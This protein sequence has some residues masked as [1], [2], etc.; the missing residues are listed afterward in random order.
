MV[1]EEQGLDQIF[2]AVVRSLDAAPAVVKP[3]NDDV[4]TS[5]RRRRRNRRQAG[6]A[7]SPAIAA[8]RAPYVQRRIGVF[9]VL[10]DEGAELIE[11]NAETIL[12]EIGM[13]FRD[14]PEVLQIL[15][16]AGA[17]V[18]GERVRFERGMCRKIIQASAPKSFT[19]HARNPANTVRIGAENTVFGPTFGAPFVHDLDNGRRYATLEDQRNFVKL[20]YLSPGL[21]HS[22]GILSEPVDLPVNKRHF[23]IVYSHIRYSDK[24]FF[25]SMLGTERA[26]DSVTMAKLVFGDEFVENNTV[27]YS[28][29]N[30]NAPLVLDATM[31]GSLKTYARHNQAVAISPFILSGAMSPCT[32]AGTLSQ[33]FAEVLGGLSLVQLVRPGAPCL[34]GTF[35]SAISMQSGAPTFGTPEGSKIIFGAAKL[36]RRLGVPYH[37]MGALNASKLP[38]AQAGYEGALTMQSALL[39]GANYII[40]AAGWLESGLTMGYEKFVIDADRCAAMEVFARGIELD[41]NQQA[42]DAV[43]EVGP[44]GHY[45]GCEHTQQNFR[46]A[47]YRSAVADY[48]S[49]EQWSSEGGL[50]QAQKANRIWKQMLDDYQAPDIDSAV[51][52]ALLEF[53]TRRKASMPDTNA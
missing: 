9:D 46:S 32:V 35:A 40:H 8:P 19:Q 17:D 41:E 1:I 49:F 39:A 26:Q 13:E 29:S 21:H 23:D 43:R 36:A 25:G 2:D 7:D 12:Q 15:K 38:D 20:T 22:G 14:D 33:L 34:F 24:P 27:L 44:G 18:N 30:V 6:A 42:L 50:D 53:M 5:P 37:S 4:S 28:V 51:D 16:D 31:S 45:L 11:H 10:S 48:N 52:E 3:R 47:F